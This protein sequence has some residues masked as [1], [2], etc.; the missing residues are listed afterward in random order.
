MRPIIYPYKFGS[1][2]AKALSEELRSRGLRAK[3]VRADGNYVPFSSH[4]IVTWGN[5][6]WPAWGGHPLTDGPDYLDTNTVLNKPGPVGRAGNKLLAFQAMKEGG[7]QV[8][9]FTNDWEVSRHWEGKVVTRYKLHG[10]SGDGIV[11]ID[12]EEDT[13][14]S[15]GRAPLYVKYIKKAKEFRVHVF[16]GKVID[17][18]QK[19]KRTEVPSEE[20]NYQVRN[21]A[22]GW[23]YCRDD[24]SH[25]E[26]VLDSAIAAVNV[27]GLDFGAVDI[28][29]NSHYNKGYV[30]EV[31]TA[32]GLEGTSV[33]LYADAI[34]T[35]LGD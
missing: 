33:K 18:Q 5:S 12:T 26:S 21:H 14:L 23:V 9:E 3:R 8:P 4:L 34:Q 2:S 22:N 20:V 11:I 29:W 28:I 7:V 19:R 15:H 17:V 13:V 16:N 27:L 32:P 31:N 6:S 35:L 1:K 10:H 25:D 24:I 30:L